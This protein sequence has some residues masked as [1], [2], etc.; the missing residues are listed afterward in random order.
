MPTWDTGAERR[1]RVRGLV[2][3]ADYPSQ[4]LFPL[5]TGEYYHITGSQA[6]SKLLDRPVVMH[7]QPPWHISCLSRDGS[8]S[9]GR[10][11]AMGSL[12][13]QWRVRHGNLYA[14]QRYYSLKHQC[15]AG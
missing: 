5:K 13:N 6:K 10:S 9:M 15:H 8:A 3:M 11:A 7:A 1:G 4:E 12:T 2:L 14:R